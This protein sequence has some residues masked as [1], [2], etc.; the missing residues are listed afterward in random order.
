MIED[1]HHEL[2]LSKGGHRELK[3][4]VFIQT[5]VTSTRKRVKHE[6]GEWLRVEF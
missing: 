6:G 4:E 1:S 5:V 3:L 2:R